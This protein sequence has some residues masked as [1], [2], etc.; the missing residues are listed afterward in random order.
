MLNSETTSENHIGKQVQYY[1]TTGD[2]IYRNQNDNAYYV[3]CYIGRPG[4]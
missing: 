3:T 4:L 1:G 2:C